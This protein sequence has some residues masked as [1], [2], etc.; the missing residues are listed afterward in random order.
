VS[1][2]WDTLLST[3]AVTASLARATLVPVGIDQ[4]SIDQDITE[5]AQDDEPTLRAFWS[6]SA[7][8]READIPLLPVEPF[9]E[10]LAESSDERSG[11]RQRWLATAGGRPVGNALLVLPD[12]DNTDAAYLNV[13]VHPESRRRGIGRALL[14]VACARL[15]AE[16]RTH[17]IGHGPE[18]LDGSGSPCVAWAT[19]VG[20]SRAL[21]EICRSL[22]LDDVGDDQVSALEAEATAYAAGY[23][24]VQWVGP[25]SDDIIDDI[26]VLTGRMS[27]DAP[28][29]DLDWEPEVWDRERVREAE[30]RTSRLGRQWV[31]TAARHVESGHV[32]AYTDI[33][34][35]PL[36]ESAA[37]QWMTIVAPEH[38][39]RRL[40]LLVKAANLRALRHELPGVERVITWNADSNAHMIAINEAL[41]FVPRLRFGQWQLQVPR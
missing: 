30:A 36:E 14:A 9:E 20:A 38:R 12:L 17:V 7:A 29:G 19:A 37:F 32:V 31:T 24:L 1:T 4:N 10:V 40:G 3:I 6:V 33:G 28:L 2:C 8:V 26:A 41:G 13:E 21:D 11:R 35:S 16:H 5:I 34:W 27:T 15:R 25:C 23:E 39:G 18:P 22:E